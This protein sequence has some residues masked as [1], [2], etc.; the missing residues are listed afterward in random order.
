MF[1]Q[2]ATIKLDGIIPW[3]HIPLTA[4]GVLSKNACGIIMRRARLGALTP[5]VRDRFIAVLILRRL[6]VISDRGGARAADRQIP[7]RA[8]ASRIT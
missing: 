7:Q 8:I 2:I 5:S 4:S 1:A 3:I 6:C